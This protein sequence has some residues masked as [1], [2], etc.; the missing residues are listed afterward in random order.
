MYFATFIAQA[1]EQLRLP[2]S[3][4]RLFPAG[5]IAAGT[6]GYNLH[7]SWHFTEATLTES[8]IELCNGRPSMVEASLPYWLGTVKSFCPW[9]GYVHAELQ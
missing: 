1:R 8:S 5:P 6:C 2:E 9:S 3:Q 7:W 4:R